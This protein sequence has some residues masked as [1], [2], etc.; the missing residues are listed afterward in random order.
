M[1]MQMYPG[2]GPPIP[3]PLWVRSYTLHLF[4]L[5]MIT[6]FFIPFLGHEYSGAWFTCRNIH[7]GP[8]Y[9]DQQPQCSIRSVELQHFQQRCR[10]EWERLPQPDDDDVTLLVASY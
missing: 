6:F 7:S 10:N 1:Q 9:Y 3:F 5:I 8:R 4:S 2:Y